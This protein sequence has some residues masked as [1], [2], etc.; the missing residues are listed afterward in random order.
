MSSR[1][2]R[3]GPPRSRWVTE[4]QSSFR[5]HATYRLPS[6]ATDNG[7]GGWRTAGRAADWKREAVDGA[8]G[9]SRNCPPTHVDPA[10]LAVRSPGPSTGASLLVLRPPFHAYNVRSTNVLVPRMVRRRRD[11]DNLSRVAA[12]PSSIMN[13]TEPPPVL[14]ADRDGTI[15]DARARSLAVAVP[16][17]M[18]AVHLTDAVAV[19]S[20]RG[21]LADRLHAQQVP[22]R[23]FASNSSSRVAECMWW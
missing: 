3:G 1:T 16:A 9:A 7:V 17:A 21:T 19:T 13:C 5:W 8:V 23:A 10:A 4:H 12:S 22:N 14:P 18:C 11:E 20:S 2:P 6:A 15:R